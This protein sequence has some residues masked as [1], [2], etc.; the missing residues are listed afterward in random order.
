MGWR[1][2]Y[3]A[4]DALAQIVA[5]DQKGA[6]EAAASLGWVFDPDRPSRLNRLVAGNNYHEPQADWSDA[7]VGTPYMVRN[8]PRVAD[9]FLYKHP[10][11]GQPVPATRH[12]PTTPATRR[13]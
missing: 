5:R 7:P 1:H 9:L 2:D 12:H 8:F 13:P 10:L 6:V 11:G 4:A 3:Q